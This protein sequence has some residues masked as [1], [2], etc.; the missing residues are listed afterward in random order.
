MVVNEFVECMVPMAYLSC[1]VAA[2]FGPNADVIGTVA[3]SYWS[4]TS[5]KDI[6]YTIHVIVLYFAIDFMST[7]V[8][9]VLLEFWCRIN[10]MNA[11]I[12][13]ITEFG[14]VF[15]INLAAFINLVS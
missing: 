4:F 10:L 7:V 2:Y 6:E 8:S 1:L 15:A 9:Y 13:M 11:Y 5:I 12:S 3:N 14:F